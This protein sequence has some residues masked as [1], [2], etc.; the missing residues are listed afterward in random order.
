METQP[1]PLTPHIEK[2]VREQIRRLRKDGIVAMGMRN[3]FQ[4]TPTPPQHLAIE[5][6]SNIINYRPTFERVAAEVAAELKFP[7]LTE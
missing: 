1:C 3:L 4:V 6:E 2:N 7:I 5:D